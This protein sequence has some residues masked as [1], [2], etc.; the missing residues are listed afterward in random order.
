MKRTLS[1]L[2]ALTLA[3]ALLVCPASAAAPGS[4]WLQLDGQSVSLQGLAGRYTAVQITLNL[5]REAAGSF[6]FASTLSTENTHTTYTVSGNSLTLYIA[7]KSALGLSNALPLG[8]LA[9]QGLTVASVPSL[10]LVNVGPNDT[11]EFTASALTIK[12][13]PTQG[14]GYDPGPGWDNDWDNSW[15]SGVTRYPVQAAPGTAGGSVQFSTTHAAPGETVVVTASPNSGYILNSL[16]V[17]DSQGRGVAVSSL[18]GGKWSFA[19][20]SSAVTVAVTFAPPQ[21][22][23]LPFCDVAQGDWF[24]EAVAYVYDTK[25]MNGTSPDQFSP[26]ATTTRGMIVTILYR[27]EGSPAAGSSSFPDVPQGEYYAA[28]VAW[29]AANGVVNGYETGLFEPQNPITRE[30]MAAI[31]YRYAQRKG[32]DVSGGA[33]LSLYAD[34][35]RV[36]PYAVDAMAWAVHTGLITGVDSTTLQPGGSAVRAQ[37]AT[38]LMRFCQYAQAH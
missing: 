23:S 15:G 33:D 18:G 27:Y 20:P 35:G 10:K 9:A 25:L 21:P 3:A 30:Q 8:S 32:L 11:E 34:A 36:S 2:L 4:P 12:T 13:A 17:T 22:A 5:N 38:I 1:L 26:W 6:E 37:V 7:S 14:G 31:L 16:A 19:M 24:R 28:P 29:A